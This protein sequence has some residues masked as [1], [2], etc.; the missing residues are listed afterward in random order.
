MECGDVV[1]VA[2]AKPLDP[3]ESPAP[4]SLLVP[5]YRGDSAHRVRRAID[6]NTHEQTR[7]PAQ[8]VIVR[9]GP[10]PQEITDELDRISAASAVPV[11]RVELEHNAGL[12]NALNTGLLWCS[13]DVVARADADDISYPDRFERQLPLIEAGADLVGASMH[14]IGDDE[15]TPLALRQAPV[16]RSEIARVAKRRNPISHPSVV[17]RL[18]AVEAVGGYEHVPMAED[19]W[20]WA[21]M[22]HAG[23]DVRN[24]SEP[25]VGYRVSAG[26]YERR[27]GPR[28][29]LAEMALQWKLRRLGYVGFIQWATNVIVRGGYRFVPLKAR[30]TAY[31][32]MVG[33]RNS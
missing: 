12:T 25:L 14:E 18:S 28:V 27:G 29:F 26:S 33:H 11:V 7:P 24:V 20:L 16:G 9:D 22:L 31:R 13:H 32:F 6:S 17:F 10:V 21:R 15:T 2:L 1:S 19:Y 8:V 3:C 23:A 30:E 5:V 4:F